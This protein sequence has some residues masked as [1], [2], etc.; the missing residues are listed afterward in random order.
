[1]KRLA[2]FPLAA[3]VFAACQDATQVTELDTAVENQPI[4]NRSSGISH[5][6]PAHRPSAINAFAFA[7]NDEIVDK[8]STDRTPVPEMEVTFRGHGD[9]L[10]RFCA[11][12]NMF[13][14]ESGANQV[15]A[16]L[17]GAQLGDEI[18]FFISSNIAVVPRCFEWIAEDLNGGTHTVTIFW[19][20]T[21]AAGSSLIGRFHASVLTVLFD[22]V[23]FPRARTRH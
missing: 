5:R 2:L 7:K 22:A 21:L 16:E 19:R 18:Q 12:G 13:G 3:L 14:G 6:G 8:T 15:S 23:R 9:A 11:N 4:Q 1:M 10:V 20:L 17:D